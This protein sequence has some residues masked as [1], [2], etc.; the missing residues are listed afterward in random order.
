MY[1]N[2]DNIQNTECRKHFLAQQKYLNIIDDNIKIS[3]NVQNNCHT[4]YTS[5]TPEEDI[6]GTVNT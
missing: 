4:Y 6:K 5:D 3:N 2:N 1:K